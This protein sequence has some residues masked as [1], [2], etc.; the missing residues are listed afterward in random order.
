MQLPP[1]T[2]LNRTRIT[3]SYSGDK[4]YPSSSG[5]F[6]LTI[7]K[8]V[9]KT[10]LSCTPK[11]AAVETK[12]IKCTATVIGY[13]PTG[14]ATLSQIGGTGIVGYIGP[15]IPP[16]L[17]KTFPPLA[18]EAK[19]RGFT[20]N[21]YPIF[22]NAATAFSKGSLVVNLVGLQT[23]TVTVQAVYNGDGN[24][25]KSVGALTLSVIKSSKEPKEYSLP[26]SQ[27]SVNE[28]TVFS[29]ELNDNSGS[30]GYVWF[31]SWSP[32]IT[33]SGNVISVPCS[34]IGCTETRDYFFSAT[35]SG[36][37][38]LQYRQPW[39]KGGSETPIIITVN[40]P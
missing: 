29:I 40:V 6:N 23:G 15:P 7:A 14:N 16:P 19:P 8:K 17:N 27:I 38:V 9:T 5:S 26:V 22:D 24:N 18:I 36:T 39:P 21:T 28:N 34:L 3:A 37:I 4:H 32:S 13:Y 30:T 25:T 12:I 1:G 35:T 10:I 20:N 33:Y 31:G 11:S 2:G